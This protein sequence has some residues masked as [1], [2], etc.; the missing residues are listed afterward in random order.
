M[1]HNEKISSVLPKNPPPQFMSA[2]DGFRKAVLLLAALSLAG[3]SARALPDYEPFADATSSGGT[4]YAVGSFLAGQT[5]A[6][7]QRWWEL[8]PNYG[9]GL[10]PQPTIAAG[11]LTVPGLYSAGG[12]R[13]AA[14]GGNGDSARLNLSVGAGGIQSGSVYFSFAM[15]L[16][17]LTGLTAG[18]AY[19]AGFNNVQ[20]INAGTATPGTIVTRVMTRSA[21]GGY[22]IGVQEGSSGTIG[23]AAWDPNVFTTSDTIFLVGSYTFNSGTGDDVS[24]LWVNPSSATFGA[25]TEPTGALVSSGGTDIARIA[26]FM[27]FDR[28]VNEPAGGLIDDLRF[29][30]SWA[31]VTPIPEPSVIALGALGLACLRLRR[32]SRKS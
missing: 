15:K 6:A 4:S 31:D 29:G 23:N 5:N 28:T 8:G 18:G 2:R 3:A 30:Q 12:G 24:Q 21:T 19:W 25:A 13:S 1:T 16:T 10:T 22:N 7:G 11:D 17:D 27:L 14:F 9:L 20:G 32:L 26:S